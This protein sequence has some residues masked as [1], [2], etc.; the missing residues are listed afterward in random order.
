MPV[1]YLDRYLNGE[2]EAVWAELTALGAAIRDDPLA[3][4]AQAVARETMTRARA[5]V[6]LLVERLTTLDYR[7]V[8]DVLGAPPTPWLPPSPRSL[9]D[10]RTIEQQ[11]GPLPLSLHAWYEEVGAVDF[12]GRHPHLSYYSD[13]AEGAVNV[14]FMGDLYSLS[15]PPKPVEGM[16]YQGPDADPLVIWPCVEENEVIP[17]DEMVPDVPAPGPGPRYALA[18]APDSIHKAGESGGDPTMIYLPDP[19]MD[20]PLHGDR[21]G[22][23]F[24]PYLRLCFAWG[25]FPGL[26]EA[27]EP[28][29]AELAFLTKELLPL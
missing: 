1:T 13:F 5:N 11:Y 2:H 9:A 3:T 25:G 6:A 23:L 27:D 22:M 17:L 15:A 10:L 26:R 8:S 28:P 7:F 14:M 12:M 20:A 19:A 4:D 18:L 24:V 16:G 29:R 21:E